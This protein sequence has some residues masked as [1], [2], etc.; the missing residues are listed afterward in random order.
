MNKLRSAGIQ[1]IG[2][3]P[4][5]FPG[6]SEN[7]QRVRM[8]VV[9]GLP[10]V[11]MELADIISEVAYPLYFLDFET[12]NP[13]LPAYLGTRPYQSIPFQWSLHVIDS[14]GNEPSNVSFLHNGNDDPRESF[15]KS[16]IEAIGTHGTIIVYSSYEKM[17]IERL[18]SEFPKYQDA[19]L[20]LPGRFLD[21]L[22]VVRAHCYHPDFHGSY[23]IKAVLPALAPD[24]TYNDLEIR[25]GSMAA[26][27]F[28][29]MI[30][31]DTQ[32]SEREQIRNA[33]LEYCQRDT[34]AM[35][36]ILHALQYMSQSRA[37]TTP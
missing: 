19:L 18:A 36:R 24:M 22:A 17:V 27:S 23:S 6:L 7:Q 32:P 4:A 1:G 37:Y 20:A 21:L 16:L 31:P 25:E 29:R 5:G 9:S 33:L 2:D 14:P 30:A 28:A 13:A 35:V 8:A 10:Y 3:I 11:G 34:Y 12:F 15:T 26:L